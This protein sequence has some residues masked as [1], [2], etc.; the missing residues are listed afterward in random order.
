LGKMAA[1]E[2]LDFIDNADDIR[3]AIAA[4]EGGG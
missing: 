2:Y 4:R 3:R 1:S